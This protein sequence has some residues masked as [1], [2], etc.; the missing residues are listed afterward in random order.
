MHLVAPFLSTACRR[1]CGIAS[2]NLGLV[3]AFPDLPELDSP[4]VSRRQSRKGTPYYSASK[5]SVTHVLPHPNQVL[6]LVWPFL[7]PYERHAVCTATPV[8]RFIAFLRIQASQLD[9]TRLLDQR[10]PRS[11]EPYDRMHSILLACALLRF[12]FNYANFLRWLGGDY[13]PATRDWGALQERL[14]N[15]AEQPSAEGYPPVDLHLALR[16]LSEGVPLQGQYCCSYD[17]VAARNAY[18]NHPPLVENRNAVWE[19]LQK[20][21]ASA[22]HLLLPRVLWRVLPGVHL[23][24]MTWVVRRGKGRIVIDPSTT[25]TPEDTGAANAAIPPPKPG[26]IENPAVYYGNALQRHWRHIWNMRITH[27]EDD[28]LLY[29]DDIDAAFHRIHYNPDAALAF[30]Y[31]FEDFVIIP[32]GMIFGARNSPPYFCLVSELRAHVATYDKPLRA[33]P[34]SPFIQALELPTE[35]EEALSAAVADTLNP[36]TPVATPD[37]PLH[38]VTPHGESASSCRADGA[39]QRTFS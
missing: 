26:S 13:L 27:P 5:V 14:T 6:P 38:H 21:E 18:N 9:I 39:L 10:I 36:G 11:D 28:I 31:V 2:A 23:S 17:D 4:P 24:F 25:L 37:G 22:F 34:F 12:R 8:L 30:A 16:V 32:V 7:T 1:T 33:A 15:V 29:K 20:E 19:K 3:C 35:P